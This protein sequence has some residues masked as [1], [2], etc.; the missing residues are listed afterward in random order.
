MPTAWVARS[1]TIN[2]YPI[3]EIKKFLEELGVYKEFAKKKCQ[4]VREGMRKSQAW[5]HLIETE[6]DKYGPPAWERSVSYRVACAVQK[7]MQE[8]IARAEREIRGEDAKNK[9]NPPAQTKEEPKDK[10]KRKPGRPRK[11]KSPEKNAELLAIEKEVKRDRKVTAAAPLTVNDCEWVLQN[12][13]TQATI[14]DA[15]SPAAW[16]LLTQARSSPKVF[17]WVLDH[18]SP[19]TFVDDGG[20]GKGWQY[21]PMRRLT[22]IERQ[23]QEELVNA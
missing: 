21:D 6:P 2:G 17:E 19:K 13:Q 8:A 3:L 7:E 4:L 5:R 11:Q 15:P 1:S 23:I 20:I 9:D 14:S 18:I 12:M 16:G 10:P 22:Q